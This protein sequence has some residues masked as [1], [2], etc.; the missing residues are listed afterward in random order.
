[1][2]PKYRNASA[3]GGLSGRYSLGAISRQAEYAVT[4]VDVGGTKEKALLVGVDREGG[5]LREVV[6]AS[7]EA[8]TLKGLKQHYDGMAELIRKVQSN[9]GPEVK[10]LPA[11]CVGTPGR[12]VGG[13]I[14]PGSAQNLG[15]GKHEFDGVKPAEELERR[16]KVKAY[17]GNDAVAQMGAALNILLGT[18]ET[19]A[20][21]KARTVAYIGPGTGLGGGFARVDGKGNIG[22]MTDGHIYDLLVPGYETKNEFRFHVDGRELTA[23]LPEE[24]LKA[25]DLLSGRAVRQIACALDR[26]AVK[27]GLEPV[28]LPNLPGMEKALP[29]EWEHLLDHNNSKPPVG[30]MAKYIAVN[31]L[32]SDSKNARRARR[33][34]EQI[35]GFEGLMLGRVVEALH[36]GRISKFSSQAQ[37][38]AADKEAVKG[39]KDFILGG[40]ML[41]RGVMGGIALER[42]ASYLKS[43]F[44]N[45]E[46][47][48][49]VI[50]DVDLGGEAAYG[51][52][53]FAGKQQIR[54]II[55]A[56]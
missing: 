12:L 20:K 17:V 45:K 46:F 10:I 56:V 47:N 28:F 41:T 5:L 29:E 38:P 49:H 8:P 27:A 50:G 9:A 22:F 43:R 14:Q 39:V 33:A 21:I 53:A 48:L 15:A 4:L 30:D 52:Y 6:L 3:G 55:E 40:S 31:I 24:T 2:C 13:V 37:W 44:P 25:E 54:K 42:A 26:A 34:A 1:M 23:R 19:A 18:P 51:A 11:V 7:E 32:E 36:L 35:A 16:L